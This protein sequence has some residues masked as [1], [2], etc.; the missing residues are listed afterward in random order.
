VETA[1][2]ILTAGQIVEVEVHTV[3]VFGVFCHYK[4]EDV[5]VLIPETSWIASYCS[6]EQ[7][8]EPGDRLLIKIIHVDQATGKVAGSIKELYP[9]PWEAGQLAPGTDHQSRV[10]RYVREADR[11]NDRP[12]YLIELL[13]GAY[14]MLCAA[15][16]SL[17]KNQRCTVTVSES[18]PFK[19]A[20][21][22]AVKEG[23]N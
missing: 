12:G 11:C 19:R 22:V 7:F 14:A 8:A 13:P 6:C 1:K 9:N 16:L 15:G 10:V 3:A 21:K 17:T 20:V 5:L 18:D 23:S 4:G 2:L